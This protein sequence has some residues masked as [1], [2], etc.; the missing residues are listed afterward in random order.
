MAQRGPAQVALSHLDLPQRGGLGWGMSTI[1]LLA[2][3]LLASATAQPVAA[4]PAPPQ[5]TPERQGAGRVAEVRMPPRPSPHNPVPLNNPAMWAMPMDYP[6]DALRAGAEG[7]TRFALDVGPDGAVTGC[8]II[9]S[10]GF[11]SL[12]AATCQVTVARARFSPGKDSAGN[13]VRGEYSN[14]ISWQIPQFRVPGEGQFR[15]V[16]VVEADGSITD[17]VVQN[18]DGAPQSGRLNRDFCAFNR[19][20]KPLLDAAGKPVRRRVV[21]E[22]RVRYEDVPD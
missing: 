4:P 13:A 9:A 14:A 20:A 15:A 21:M 22:N 1:L 18:S 19:K 8:R 16:F 12:D 5:S 10:S 2:P 7:L 17:C 3:A 11:A 6:A